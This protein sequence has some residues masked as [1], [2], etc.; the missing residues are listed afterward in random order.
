MINLAAMWIRKNIPNLLTVL[1]LL[2]GSLAVVFTFNGMLWYA[3]WLV[4]LAALFDLFDGAVARILNVSSP[5]GADLDSLADTV[6]FGLAPALILYKMMWLNEFKEANSLLSYD[7]FDRA[8]GTEIYLI[9][10]VSFWMVAAGVIRLAR[11]NNDPRQSTS[12]IGLPIP[13]NGLFFAFLPIIFQDAIRH[14]G[15]VYDAV[16]YVLSDNSNL[17]I[18]ALLIPSLM[19]APIPMFSLKI[20]SK[21]WKDYLPQIVFLILGIII[22]IEGRFLVVPVLILLYIIYSLISLISRK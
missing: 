10:F 14:T 6:S 21:N 8:I 2:S 9:A 4:L 1:N 11:F 7:L 22:F 12:F 3:G 15:P 20:K 18:L 16:L 5:I 13:S 17:A 19:L